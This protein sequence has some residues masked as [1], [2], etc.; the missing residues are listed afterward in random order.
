MFEQE[1]V[2]LRY[3]H[4]LSRSTQLETGPETHF[5]LL[6]PKPRPLWNI[7]RGSIPLQRYMARILLQARGRRVSGK[8]LQVAMGRVGRNVRLGALQLMKTFT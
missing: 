2:V 5:G 3:L 1:N 4:W 7:C 8:L 6:L